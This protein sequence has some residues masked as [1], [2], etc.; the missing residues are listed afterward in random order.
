M[1]SHINWPNRVSLFRW[2]LVAVAIL[3]IANTPTGQAA[4]PA[5]VGVLALAVDDDAAQRL[6]L[7]DEVREKLLTLID[8]R[9][10]EA[11]S[12][13]L[14]IKDLPPSERLRRLAPF[15]AESERLGMAMLTVEQRSKLYQLRLQR[16]GM[17][18]LAEE[19]LQKLLGL[20]D[21]QRQ[22][23]QRLMAERSEAM[24]EGGERERRITGN[25]FERRLRSIL[26]DTQKASWDQLAGLGPG[27]QAA[28]GL[29]RLKRR[30]W[31]TPPAC[32]RTTLRPACRPRG[33]APVWLRTP[34]PQGKRGP[35]NRL[36]HRPRRP[37]MPVRRAKLP[38][39]RLRPKP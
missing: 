8:Q 14:Q 22:A 38:K 19:N 7:A 35:L 17:A 6:E 36:P 9:E 23:I 20:E 39:A 31:V 26:N 32:Q 24:T 27:A 11:V 33:S 10:R 21:E 2:G 18:S 1:K 30:T 3:T 12:L 16:A 28:R 37:R 4:D 29:R 13:A 15:V 34:L 5:F 25:L